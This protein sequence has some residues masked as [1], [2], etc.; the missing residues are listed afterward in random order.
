MILQCAH[1]TSTE[2][3]SSIYRQQQRKAAEA[4]A[5]EYFTAACTTPHR[6]RYPSVLKQAIRGQANTYRLSNHFALG[7]Q[8]SPGV[9]TSSCLN[10]N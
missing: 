7:P 8:T 9:P 5:A 1:A 4:G 3:R 6:C 10:E 2:W